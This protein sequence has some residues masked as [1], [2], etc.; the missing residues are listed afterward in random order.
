MS[1]SRLARGARG[2]FDDAGLPQPSSADAMNAP[3]LPR[4]SDLARRLLG[5]S[6]P[7]PS[8]HEWLP[9]GLYPEASAQE[10]APLSRLGARAVVFLPLPGER[11]GLFRFRDS[12][13]SVL[14]LFENG[15]CRRARLDFNLRAASQLT[16]TAYAGGLIGRAWIQS[17]DEGLREWVATHRLAFARG[18]DGVWRFARPVAAAPIASEAGVGARAKIG[19]QRAPGALSAEFGSSGYL[20]IPHPEAFISRDYSHAPPIRID[21]ERLAPWAHALAEGIAERLP[22]SSAVSSASTIGDGAL[23]CRRV[24]GGADAGVAGFRDFRESDPCSWFTPE[25]LRAAF[26]DRL[27]ELALSHFFRQE[28][29]ATLGRDEE[30]GAPRGPLPA[31]R[32]ARL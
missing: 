8:D 18:A 27:M 15:D 11:R 13:G 10:M 23:A 1:P 22:G 19:A 30:T 28:L 21:A 31:R 6:A 5:L 26:P 9:A 4:F 12:A 2:A 25:Q 16:V 17:A 32:V 14:V 7:S 29:A 20:L 3:L 24:L